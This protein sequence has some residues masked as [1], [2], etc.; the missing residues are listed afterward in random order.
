MKQEWTANNLSLEEALY[1][2]FL[3]AHEVKIIAVHGILMEKGKQLFVSM[4]RKL[5]QN[6][7]ELQVYK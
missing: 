1:K 7:R 2:W 5:V 3:Y 4:T 6:L